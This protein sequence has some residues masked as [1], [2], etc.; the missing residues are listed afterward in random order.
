MLFTKIQTNVQTYKKLF[1]INYIIEHY[2]NFRS[3][4]TECIICFLKLVIFIEI[5]AYFKF[6][7]SVMIIS[8]IIL[9]KILF[10][11]YVFNLR[12]LTPNDML[13]LAFKKEDRN[14]MIST[15]FFEEKMD[16]EKIRAT[17]IEG[18]KKNKKMRMR[19]VKYFSMYFWK[20]T[21]VE[22]A[23]SR[24]RIIQREF[25]DKEEV[26]NFKRRE[27]NN[28]I[29]IEKDLPY[30]FLIVKY[31]N[32]E[33]GAVLFKVDHI[34]SDGLGMM[35]F[36]LTLADQYDGSYIPAILK[37][38]QKIPIYYKFF[39]HILNL[40]LFP[41]YSVKLLFS[42][43]IHRSEKNPFKRKTPPSGETKFAYTKNFDFSNLHKISKSLKISFNDLMLC[44]VSSAVNKFCEKY[45]PNRDYKYHHLICAIPIGIKDIPKSTEDVEIS[46]DILGAIVPLKRIDNILH[47]YKCVSEETK[48]TVKN[49]LSTNSSK[50]LFRLVYEF[51][52]YDFQKEITKNVAD[53]VDLAV[54]NLPGPAKQVSYSNCKVEDILPVMSVAY[55]KAFLIV[56]TYNDKVR[57]VVNLENKLDIDVNLLANT[58][59]EE[60]E[61][62]LR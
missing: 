7:S 14:T 40:L 25:A 41:Y 50:Y 42:S 59:E 56:A 45:Y 19:I 26:I 1:D 58:I 4:L 47:H 60:L 2:L 38:I 29:P 20:E 39:F 34:L 36:T 51:V 48:K 18:I 12:E 13:I 61:L 52:P 32:R 46:N 37:A 8:L 9:T 6:L 23:A 57:I 17:L 22:E 15:F 53:N 30:E 24:V 54:S 11:K 3:H 27:V 35:E 31:K 33:G 49:A 43:R 5:F 28:H 16:S 21:S 62:L 10:L 55:G 44:V